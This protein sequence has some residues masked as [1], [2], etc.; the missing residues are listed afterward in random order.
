MKKSQARVLPGGRTQLDANAGLAHSICPRVSRGGGL[1]IQSLVH[2]SLTAAWRCARVLVYGRKPKEGSG[3]ARWHSDGKARQG[4]KDP[5]WTTSNLTVLLETERRSV[6]TIQLRSCMVET[7][8]LSVSNG[9][10]PVLGSIPAALSFSVYVTAGNRTKACTAYPPSLTPTLG[11]VRKPGLF[12]CTC[13]VVYRRSHK[14][15]FW[16]PLRDRAARTSATIRSG[17]SDQHT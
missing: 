8:L 15:G 1:C 4:I 13:Y 7:D 10:W 9:F 2:A 6:S 5:G 11:V 12:T 16:P 3:G 14:E 17:L